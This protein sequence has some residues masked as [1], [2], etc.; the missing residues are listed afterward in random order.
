M[1]NEGSSIVLAVVCITSHGEAACR[2]T[3][4]LT[5]ISAEQ[6]S[7]AQTFKLFKHTRNPIQLIEGEHMRKSCA[8]QRMPP[9]PTV[10]AL[11]TLVIFTC[12]FTPS[13]DYNFKHFSKCFLF[14]LFQWTLVKATFSLILSLPWLDVSSPQEPVVRFWLSPVRGAQADGVQ[15]QPPCCCLSS[16]A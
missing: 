6:Y 4:S 16:P 9:C 11:A 13:P 12:M 10:Y 2:S 3:Q 15:V 8:G 7:K 1:L 14:K 5:N